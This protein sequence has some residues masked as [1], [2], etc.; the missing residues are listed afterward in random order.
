MTALLYTLG[1]LAFVFAI[2]ASIGI[3]IMCKPVPYAKFVVVTG[4]VASV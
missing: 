3:G 2:L 1:V 4:K